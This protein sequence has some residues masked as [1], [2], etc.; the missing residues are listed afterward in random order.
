MPQKNVER[1]TRERTLLDAVLRHLEADAAVEDRESPDFLIEIG[2]RIVG[3]D[4]TELYLPSEGVK[5]QARESAIARI[6]AKAQQFYDQTDG[7]PLEVAV[8]FTSGLDP[9]VR[10]DDLARQIVDIVCEM[11]MDPSDYLEWQPSGIDRRRLLLP[12]NSIRAYRHREGVPSHWTAPQAGW[13]GAVRPDFLQV[14]IDRKAESYL[15]TAR[16]PARYG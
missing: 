4:V 16:A 11:L 1:K 12:L 7:P 3:V 8:G 10:R 6:V 9:Q 13:V 14:A 15:F 5:P 2:S